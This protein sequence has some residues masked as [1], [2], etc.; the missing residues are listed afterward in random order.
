MKIEEK[1]IKKLYISFGSDYYA[2]YN[3]DDNIFE[4]DLCK[5]FTSELKQ[6]LIEFLNRCEEI[7][8]NK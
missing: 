5:V 7:R 2:Q 4:I 8:E 1:T 3:S 6:K